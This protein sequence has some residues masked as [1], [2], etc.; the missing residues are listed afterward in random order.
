LLAGSLLSKAILA[1]VAVLVISCPCAFGVAASS[2]LSLTV[3]NL[4][5]QGILIK[6]PAILEKLPQIDTVCFDKTGT[7]TSGNLSLRELHWFAEEDTGQLTALKSLE[8]HSKHPIGISLYNA[9]EANEADALG[10]IEVPGK[11][12]TGT[13]A[14]IRYAVGKKE[15]FARHNYPEV[16]ASQGVSRVWFGCSGELPAGYIDIEDQLKDEAKDIVSHC[17]K[18]GLETYLLSGD[19]SMTTAAIAEQL[20]ISN[21]H[22][23]L[24]PDDK[25]VF[26][27]SLQEAGSQVMFV[28]DGQNDAAS[29]AG[30]DVGIAVASGADLAL[31]TAPVVVTSSGLAKLPYLLKVAK[32]TKSVMTSNFVWAFIYNLALIPFAATGLLQPAYAALLMAVSSLSVGLNSLRL[33]R[34]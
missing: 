34:I 15:L 14:G 10:V 13:V 31:V 16:I 12:I 3:F 5:R 20:Q 8:R 33:R 28:G 18:N 11:G 25:L 19:A 29:L 2:A 32:K 21:A 24:S 27:S 7:V 9:L 23:D 6:D 1:A 26:V 17:R 30:A 22:G 4:A